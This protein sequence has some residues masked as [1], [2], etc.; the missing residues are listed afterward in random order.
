MSYDERG[1]YTPPTADAPLSF[2]ARQPVRGARPIPFT[3]I[4]SVLVLSALVAAI[5]V[6]YRSGVR[7]AGQPPQTVGASIDGMKSA[8]TPEALIDGWQA[9]AA[10]HGLD[11]RVLGLALGC[12]T[13]RGPPTLGS[14]QADA[15]FQRLAAPDGLTARRSTFGAGASPTSLP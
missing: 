5:F 13:L 8:A 7:Q 10:A 3:L 14:S 6:F 2:D 9:K 1:A 4:V 11:E 15:L 12:H